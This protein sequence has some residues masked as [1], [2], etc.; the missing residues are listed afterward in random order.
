MI[1]KV[2]L[3]DAPA[4]A[5]IYNYYL[6]NTTITFDTELLT[7]KDMEK[8]IKDISDHY[9]FFIFEEE[10]VIKGYCYVT[11]WKKKCAY[12]T[13]VESTVYI[14]KDYLGQGI[15]TLL[16]KTLLNELKEI[17]IH[18]IIAC[19]TV[20]N[21][22]SVRMHEKLGFRQVSS[23]KEVGYKFDKWLDVGDW[24]LLL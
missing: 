1:R 16:M 6:E 13:T 21:D 15:G 20:P 5:D 2:T 14:H 23:F 9:P 19:I 11:L 10:S 4:I 18:A 17:G 7:V 3:N 24:E 12:N 8:K 22:E